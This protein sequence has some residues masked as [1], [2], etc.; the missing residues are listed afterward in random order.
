MIGGDVTEADS[1][2]GNESEIERIQVAPSLPPGV[3]ESSQED[4]EERDSKSDDWWKIEVVIN[5]VRNNFFFIFLFTHLRGELLR[6]LLLKV[7]RRSLSDVPTLAAAVGL[8]IAVETLEDVHPHCTQ[9]NHPSN[10]P[11][12]SG[13]VET[14][15]ETP[16]ELDGLREVLSGFSEKD[17]T[18]G[19]ADATEDHRCHSSVLCCRCDIPVACVG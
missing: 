18:E 14:P 16:E 6:H 13:E 10:S 19:N 12:A 7:E 8:E 1:G 17:E 5:L 11:A 15:D 9:W 2:K 4:I 3:D